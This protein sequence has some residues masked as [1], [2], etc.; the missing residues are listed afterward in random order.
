MGT[1]LTD[2][3]SNL[4]TS[5]IRRVFHAVWYTPGRPSSKATS[6]A[7]A[8]QLVAQGD[9]AWAAWHAQRYGAPPT[10]EQ[11]KYRR[12]S[13]RIDWGFPLL[14]IGA[15]GTGKTSMGEGWAAAQG[16]L[17]HTIIGSQQQNNHS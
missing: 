17:P 6:D 5:S 12:V 4:P 2:Q 15:P 3:I 13:S 11:T 16:L 7:K 1:P 9:A 14:G 10:P 8:D